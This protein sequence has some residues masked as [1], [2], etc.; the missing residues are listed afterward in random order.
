MQFSS[1]RTPMKYRAWQSVGTLAGTERRAGEGTCSDASVLENLPQKPQMLLNSVVRRRS[2]YAFRAGRILE[3]S[4]ELSNLFRP[5]WKHNFMFLIFE[6]Y[7]G[8][9]Q[10]S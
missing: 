5:I 10:A 9:C 3:Q 4:S 2:M 8:F 6:S 1:D 7:H